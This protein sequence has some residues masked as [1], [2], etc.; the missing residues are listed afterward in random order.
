MKAINSAT[1]PV[2][3]VEGIRSVALDLIK[4]LLGWSSYEQ[5]LLASEIDIWGER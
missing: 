1:N 4:E 3:L 2:G 5:A